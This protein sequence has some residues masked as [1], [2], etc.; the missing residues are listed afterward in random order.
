MK[1]EL[2]SVSQSRKLNKPPVRLVIQITRRIIICTKI[3]TLVVAPAAIQIKATMHAH[4]EA[5]GVAPWLQCS[6]DQ[7]SGMNQAI[8]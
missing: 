1:G 4:T 2:C 8:K 7:I 6:R 3:C 5:E